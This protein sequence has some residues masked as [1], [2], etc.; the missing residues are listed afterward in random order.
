MSV[1]TVTQSGFQWLSR[2]QDYVP[3]G[4]YACC[5]DRLLTGDIS[6]PAGGGQAHA[7]GWTAKD[8]FGRLPAPEHAGP[9]FNCL[10]RYDETGL[11]WLLQGREVIALAEATAAI[12][13]PTGAITIYR[14]DNKPALGPLGDSLH[15]LGAP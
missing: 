3:C 6:L 12:R 7:L 15:D 11:I 4:P 8:L 13:G 5:S 14:R 10:A 1:T 2:G 9:S